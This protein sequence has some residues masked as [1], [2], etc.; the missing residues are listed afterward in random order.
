MSFVLHLATL[1]KT[2]S[3]A[4]PAPKIKILLFSKLN[5]LEFISL[6]NPFPSVENKE[7]SLFEL[8]MVFTAFI[9]FA[10]DEIFPFILAAFF[11]YGRVTFN[12]FAF[13]SEKNSLIK[14]LKLYSSTL[15][16]KYSIFMFSFLENLE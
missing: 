2:L 10:S 11:L 8:T 13:L 4:A 12:P 6:I 15:Y 16:G 5:P 1:Y 9:Y 7:S 3:T 14:L